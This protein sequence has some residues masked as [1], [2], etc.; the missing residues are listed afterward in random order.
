MTTATKVTLIRVLLIPV[1]LVCMYL[2]KPYPYMI[3]VALAV[4]AIASLTDLIDGKIA[5]KY[6]QV[7]DLGK[8]L[9]PLADKVLVI[10]AMAVFCEWGIFPAWAL[11]IVL[12]REFAV[13][14]LRLIAVG[15]GRVIAAAWSGKMKTSLTMAGLCLMLFF[16]G[17]YFA[18][19]L[20]TNIH[21]NFMTVFNW[22][23]VGIIAAVTMYSGIEYFV[24]NRDVFTNEA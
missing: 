10:A 17:E 21:P 6:H 15:K 16:N 19:L 14:G 22:V 20:N 3:Y 23:I 4:F 12:T 1:F 9:D 7:S 8:F 24:K 18:D 11:M 5:R 13:T 2:A